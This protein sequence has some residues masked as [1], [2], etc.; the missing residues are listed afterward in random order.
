M[1]HQFVINTTTTPRRSLDLPVELRTTDTGKELRTTALV[2]SGATGSFIDRDFVTRHGIATRRLARPVPVL[3]VDGTPNEA[4]QITEIVDMILRYK[5]HA[6]RVVFAV[7]GL[8]KK[9]VLLG[10]TW[11]REHNPEIDWEKGEVKLSRCPRRCTECRDEVRAEKTSTAPKGVP[12]TYGSLSGHRVCFATMLRT[13]KGSVQPPPETPDLPEELDEEEEQTDGPKYEDGD[14]LYF[15]SYRPKEQKE[16]IAATSTISQR[17]A[18]GFARNSNTP[19]LSLRERLPP[20]VWDYEDVFAKTSFDTLPEHREWDHAIELT[21]DPKS[22]HRKLYPLSPVEQTELDKFL[23]E[24][25]SS[26]RIRPSKSPLAAP[27]F[28]IKKKDGSLRPVQDYRYL[29]SITVKNKY[30]LPLVDDLVQRLKGARYFTKLDVRWGYNNVRIKEG[31]EW[32]AAFRTNRGLFEPLVMFFG[33]TNSPATFQTMMNDI[34]ADLI[35]DGKV[36]IYMD[37][38]LIFAQTKEELRAITRMVLDRLRRHKLYLKAEKCEFEKEQVEYLGLVISHNRVAMDPAKIAAV[39]EWP[40]PK[41]RREVQSFLGFANFYR[42]F[43]EK[44]SHIARPLFDL[45][46][47]DHPFVWSADC[48]AAFIALK[49]KIT[50]SPILSLPDEHQPFRVKADSSDFASGGVLQ[51]LSK[52][53]GKWHPVAFL[54]KSLSPVERNYEVHDKELLAVVRCLE[55]WRHFLEGAKHPV[56]IWTDHK[57]LEYF[58]TSQNLN[59]R[60]ARWSLFLSRFDYSLHHRPGS[61]MGEPDALSRRSDHGMH[62]PDNRGIVLLDPSVFSIHAL[63]ATLV[64]GGEVDVLRDIREVLET[65]GTTEEAVTKAAK[66]LREDKSRGQ[67]RKSEWGENDG[68]LTFG[69]RIYVPDANDLRR[70]IMAQYHDSQVAGHPGRMKTLELISRDYWWPQMARHV[71]QYTST[72]ETCLR[73]KVIRRRPFGEL[74]PLETPQGR[75]EKVSVDFI[76]EL[77]DAHGFDAI[78]VTV[79]LVSKRAHFMPTTTSVDAEGSARLYYQNV[80]KLHGLPLAWIHDR[81]SVFISEFMREL[82]R[83]LGIQTS[84][85]TSHHPQ[86]DGQTERVNQELETYIRMF[87]NH[88]Q[89]DWDELLPSAEFA[90]ANHVHASTGVTPFMADTGRNPR[91]GFEP[92]VDVA[93]ANAAAFQQRMERGITE[94]KAA[95]TKAKDEYARYYNRR[96]EPA[97]AFQPGDMVLLDASD[98]RVNRASRKFAALRLGPFKVIEAV[99]KGAYRLELPPSLA[100]LHPVFPVVKLF[101]LP[102]DPFPGRRQNRPPDPLL[103]DGE[104]Y[105]E[106]EKILDSRIRYRR[107]EYLVKWAGYNDSHNQ[108]IPW[109]NLDADELIEEF[110]RDNP[111]A[112]QRH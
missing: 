12:N 13:L 98:I 94:A 70:R 68:L 105:Y 52:E 81:G 28:F 108:W 53:D 62:E 6:E 26:G 84:A 59:R 69:G 30:P 55:Q 107:T 96:R 67:V 85:S 66:A 56:E 44:F 40:R 11:L 97:P 42:R 103:V 34:F 24:N 92:A 2:D 71:G 93:D 58:R 1:P 9:D 20:S 39:A 74:V 89:N 10:Y 112:E 109:Y 7:T 16:E 15:T 8:G 5:R 25:L 63:R 101:P 37:D 61:S 65:G 57:N 99:G 90:L 31:D 4:G 47:K 35:R 80:W 45:T 23:D 41:D 49:G 18:E 77:P 38:I 54:S 75:W 50:S 106:V 27:F 82:N 100:R 72:C 83:L 91:M 111:Q 32:K 29:N 51:Q 33:L 19:S 95:L 17:I 87:C 46:K 3:N 21:A 36:C 22:P 102:N 76:T 79:D 86:T 78:M 60:Q 48:D 43:I 104:E 110:H 64:R 73:N 88:H 14:R